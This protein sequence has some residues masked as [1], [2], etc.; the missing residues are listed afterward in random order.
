M[1]GKASLVALAFCA[2]ACE[3]GMPVAPLKYPLALSPADLAAISF[4]AVAETYF[5]A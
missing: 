3:D 4:A 1:D 5:S 2:A